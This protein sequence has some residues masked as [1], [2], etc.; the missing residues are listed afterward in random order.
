MENRPRR[1]RKQ[2][3]PNRDAGKQLPG[4]DSAMDAQIWA[5]FVPNADKNAVEQT[6]VERNMTEADVRR[7]LVQKFFEGGAE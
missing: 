5:L 7:E 4:L 1:E 2:W 6:A 3:D